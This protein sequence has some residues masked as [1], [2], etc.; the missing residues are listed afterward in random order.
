MSSISHE[1][2][3]YAGDD[4]CPLNGCE[5]ARLNAQDARDVNYRAILGVI[6]CAIQLIKTEN[7]YHAQT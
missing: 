3:L 5:F 6:V 7:S 2:A 4:L 1:A